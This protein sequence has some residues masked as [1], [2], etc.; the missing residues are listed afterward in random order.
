MIIIT[1][2]KLLWWFGGLLIV[3]NLLFSVSVKVANKNL[4]LGTHHL[5]NCESCNSGFISRALSHIKMAS[6]NIPL[7]D[8]YQ[9][10]WLTTIP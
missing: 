6:L 7:L 1:C 2:D 8:L 10:Y 4:K 5:L 3:L 9:W